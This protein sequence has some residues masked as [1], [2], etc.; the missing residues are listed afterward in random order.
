M[1]D[2]IDQWL[3]SKGYLYADSLTD[4]INDCIQDLGLSNEWVSVDDRLPDGDDTYM[5]SDGKYVNMTE[6]DEE[7]EQFFEIPA[8][9]LREVTHWK[10]MPLPSE[11]RS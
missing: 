6:Y 10:P 8:C 3:E 1:K 5:V 9:L 2:K 7:G 11:K 4:M